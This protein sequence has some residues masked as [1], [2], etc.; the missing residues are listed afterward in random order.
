M[1]ISFEHFSEEIIWPRN[2]HL[3]LNEELHAF[4]YIRSRG[5]VAKFITH[6]VRTKFRKFYKDLQSNLPLDIVMYLERV[7]DIDR[8]IATCK[9]DQKKK[10]NTGED[11][12][13]DG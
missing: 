12:A 5:I 11:P 4:H 7:W 1:L 3:G 2:G 10:G 6:S 13:E 9:Y 8:F